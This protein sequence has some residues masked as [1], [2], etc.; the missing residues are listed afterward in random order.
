MAVITKMRGYPIGKMSLH[1]GVNI[2]TI[3]YY[4]RISL[5]PKPDRM[6]NGYRQY[7]HD[8][9]KRLAFIK[10]SRELGFSIDEIRG[11]LGM[12]DQQG[13]TCGDVHQVTVEHLTSVQDKIASLRK[14][15]TALIGMA[16][17]CECGDVPDCPIIETL[18]DDPSSASA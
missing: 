18:F 16:S 11:L 5:M 10:R 14:L 2:E 6:P 8:Q 13:V 1:T 17:E 7:S 9:L 3:R 15:E 12:V 4:E